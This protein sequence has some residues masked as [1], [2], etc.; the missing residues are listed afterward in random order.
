MNRFVQAQ[1]RLQCTLF[2]ESSRTRGGGPLLVEHLGNNLIQAIPISRG[3]E[4]RLAVIARQDD[5]IKTA[6]N[7]QAG[8]SGHPC[9][10]GY[11]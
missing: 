6:G 3:S 10:R 11:N 4:Q 9:H 7:M 1:S 2:P 5:V 8:R